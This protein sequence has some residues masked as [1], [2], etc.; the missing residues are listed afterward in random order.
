MF[1]N[2]FTSPNTWDELKKQNKDMLE[3]MQS[4]EHKIKMLN[5]DLEIARKDVQVQIDIAVKRKEAEHQLEITKLKSGYEKEYYDKLNK[6]LMEG[7]PQT[8][9]AQDM[10]L[11]FVEKAPVNM[12]RIGQ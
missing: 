12:P 7:T 9:F 11:K 1:A 5:S 4:Y 2:W 10:L 3:A 8:K 6:S